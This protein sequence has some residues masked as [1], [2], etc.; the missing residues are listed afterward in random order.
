MI[1]I[2]YSYYSNESTFTKYLFLRFF[3]KLALAKIVDLL[4]RAV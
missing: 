3:K 2:D 4:I 1:W